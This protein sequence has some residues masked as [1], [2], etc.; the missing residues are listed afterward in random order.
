VAGFGQQVN[1][2]GKVVARVRIKTFTVVRDVL[3]A[4]MVEMEGDN[5]TTVR[6]VF[7]ALL[8]KFGK[9]LRDI[10]VDPET[11][12]M[13]PFLI[14]LNDE[15]ISSTLDSDKPIKNG[16]ELTLIFPIGGG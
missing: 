11:G 1:G 3:G 9:S 8:E 12:V 5:L 4:D 2:R 10:I 13:A 14:R 16:D 7:Q 6:T 15:I